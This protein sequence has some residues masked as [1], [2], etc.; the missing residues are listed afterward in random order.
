MAGAIT[1]VG[2]VNRGARVNWS[3]FGRVCIAW[4]LTMPLAGLAGAIVFEVAV[5][6]PA[7]IAVV[8]LAVLLGTLATFVAWSLREAQR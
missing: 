8:L 3:V 1:G 7:W 6:P 5:V 2:L 4:L